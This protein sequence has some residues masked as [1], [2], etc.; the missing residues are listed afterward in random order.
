[1][2]TRPSYTGGVPLV[3]YTVGNY[4][5]HVYLTVPAIENETSVRY[6][7]PVVVYGIVTVSAIN[8][9]GQGGRSASVSIP[10]SIGEITLYCKL[11]YTFNSFCRST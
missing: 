11:L 4:M 6:A 9:C 1:M 5:Q 7:T 8:Y 2:W 10:Y 3:N